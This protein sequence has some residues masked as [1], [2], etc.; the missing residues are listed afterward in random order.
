MDLAWAQTAQ[1]PS[2]PG[3]LASFLPLVLIFV[4][5]YFLLIRPQQ[6]KAK[7][8][9]QMLSTLKKNDD[10]VTSGGIHGKVTGLTDAGVVLEVAPNVRIHVDRA[11]ISR[12]VRITKG[13]KASVKEAKEQ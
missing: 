10:V 1:T 13:E 12:V 8:H 7:D 11:N 3:M 6:K 9:Q 2:G 5:F 4:I